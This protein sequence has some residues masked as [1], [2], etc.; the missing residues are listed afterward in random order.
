MQC[1]CFFYDHHFYKI[2]NVKL[3]FIITYHKGNF[4]RT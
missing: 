2:N 4:V 3:K 1:V